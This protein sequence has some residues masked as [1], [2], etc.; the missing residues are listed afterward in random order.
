MLVTHLTCFAEQSD[1]FFQAQLSNM[2]NVLKLTLTKLYIGDQSEIEEVYE[3]YICHR[4][5]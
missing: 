1:I 3:G 2:N 4:H 5:Y